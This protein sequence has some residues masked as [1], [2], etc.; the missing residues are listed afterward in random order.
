MK[1]EMKLLMFNII[2]AKDY[3][4]QKDLLLLAK[5]LFSS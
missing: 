3:H 2:Y 5:Q 1:W 4:V